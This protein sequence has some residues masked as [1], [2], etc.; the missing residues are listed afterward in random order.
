MFCLLENNYVMLKIY[1]KFFNFV[2]YDFGV[3]SIKINFI[4]P[5]YIY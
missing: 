5:L 4:Y 2:Y 1:D 3:R